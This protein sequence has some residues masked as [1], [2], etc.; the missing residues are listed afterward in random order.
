MYLRLTQDSFHGNKIIINLS[1]NSKYG[2]PY[3]YPE[4]NPLRE[5]IL[6]KANELLEPYKA[7]YDQLVKAEQAAIQ[8]RST[9]VESTFKALQ[10]TLEQLLVDFPDKHPEY[11]I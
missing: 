10:P 4:A 5:P 9:Y 1:G 3:P 8:A 11:L 2:V 7:G 6:A